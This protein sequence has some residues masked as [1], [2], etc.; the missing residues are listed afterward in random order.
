[1][2]RGDQAAFG[3]IDGRQDGE[4]VLGQ[5]LGNTANTLACDRIGLDIAMH[6]QDGELEVLVHGRALPPGNSFVTSG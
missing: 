2:G 3:V 6:D 4:A 5:L 1:M